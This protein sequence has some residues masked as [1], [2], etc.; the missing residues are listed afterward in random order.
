MGTSM[1]QPLGEDWKTA[2]KRVAR[3]TS[4]GGN[5]NELNKSSA[6][7]C[8]GSLCGRIYI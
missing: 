5:F 4:L 1:L 7:A 6:L 2:L 3:T 8:M